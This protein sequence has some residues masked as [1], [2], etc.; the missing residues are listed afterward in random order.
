MLWPLELG[1]TK[2]RPSLC[3]TFS[4]SRCNAQERTH[5]HTTEVF[6]K[7]SGNLSSQYSQNSRLYFRTVCA[8]RHLCRDLE[9]EPPVLVP[10]SVIGLNS[11][12]HCVCVCGFNFESGHAWVNHVECGWRP[13]T[14]VGEGLTNRRPVVFH[15]WVIDF[16]PRGRSCIE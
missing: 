7:S 1:I 10:A 14:C 12:K 8:A 15:T 2:G 6:S 11:V 16:A 9:Q 13:S 5:E 3:W 4:Q